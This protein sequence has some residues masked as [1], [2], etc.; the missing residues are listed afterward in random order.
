MKIPRD[1]LFARHQII[2]PKLDAI[3]RSVVEELNNQETT[4]QG[5]RASF[6]ASLLGCSNNLW[7]EL[8]LPCRRIWTGLAAVWILVFIVNFS[9]RDGSPAGSG[10]PPASPEI[11]M[12]FRDQQR[13]LNELLADRSFATD[14]DRPKMYLPKSRTETLR[15]FTA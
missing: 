1:I 14:A 10:K 2:T 12:T 13:M 15:L 8:V 9:L 6:V 11:M 4:E 7:L 3:R 5:W